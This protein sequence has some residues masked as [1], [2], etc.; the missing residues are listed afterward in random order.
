[1]TC[2]ACRHSGV[3]KYTAQPSEVR[4]DKLNSLAS[5]RGFSRCPKIVLPHHLVRCRRE[6]AVT[7]L[8]KPCTLRLPTLVSASTAILMPQL[9]GLQVLSELRTPST[10]TLSMCAQLPDQHFDHVARQLLDGCAK[11]GTPR[12]QS[13]LLHNFLSSVG[14]GGA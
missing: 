4:N 8:G 5:G 13:Y 11:G 3:A 12:S 2:Y 9:A 6:L 14:K 7:A 1:M 10:Q